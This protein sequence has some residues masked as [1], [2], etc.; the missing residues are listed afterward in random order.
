[1]FPAVQKFLSGLKDRWSTV[2]PA[3]QLVIAASIILVSALMALW[4]VDKLFIYLL[5]RS[6]VEDVADVFDLNKHLARAIALAVFVAAVYLIGKAFSRSRTSRR[7]GYLG[8]VGLLIVHS[9]LLWRGTN[10]QKFTTS[11]ESIKCYVI[12][13]ARQAALEKQERHT[14]ELAAARERQQKAALKQQQRQAAELAA[15]QERERQA[16]ASCDQMA[17]NPSD[18]RKTGD[19][20]G[21]PYNDLKTNAKAAADACALAMR[22]NPEEIR[23]RYQYARALEIDDPKKALKIHEQLIHDGYLASY[24]NAGSILIG[25]YKKIPEAIK[26]FNEGVRRGDPDSMVS[27]ASLIGC[28]SNIKLTAPHSRL[29]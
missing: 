4:L 7:I 18:V 8:I 11:G 15:E 29:E 19:V 13:H 1:M 20:A 9:L 6:Y 25:T 27:L 5:A 16:V 23:Y 12:T 24:D 14:A 26:Y 17:A 2:G 21:V 28:P 22:V 3:V 10:D